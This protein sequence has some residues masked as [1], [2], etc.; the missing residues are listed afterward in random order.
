MNLQNTSKKFQERIT[1]Q[2]LLFFIKIVDR[3]FIYSYTFLYIT[4]N[5]EI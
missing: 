1:E 3:P 2:I 4:A 5:I